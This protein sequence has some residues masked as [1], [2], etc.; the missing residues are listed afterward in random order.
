MSAKYGYNL[1]TKEQNILSFIFR[2][3]VCFFSA[4]EMMIMMM[5]MMFAA[6]ECSYSEDFLW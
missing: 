4:W 6:T 5:M 2:F 1:D 3:V